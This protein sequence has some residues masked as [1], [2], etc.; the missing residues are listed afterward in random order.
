[1]KKFCFPI[2]ICF[3][4]MFGSHNIAYGYTGD[5][6]Y[7][8]NNSYSAVVFSSYNDYKDYYS[9]ANINFD[10][11]KNYDYLY[12]PQILEDKLNYITEIFITS[13]YCKL[14]FEIDEIKLTTCHFF[15]SDEKEYC[16]YYHRYFENSEIEKNNVGMEYYLF[17]NEY[18]PDQY[19]CKYNG[20]YFSISTE[21]IECDMTDYKF[22][23]VYFNQQ[24]YEYDNELYYLN[25]NGLY[26]TGWKFVGNH[27]Y[28]F[29]SIDGTAIKNRL[30]FIDGYVYQFNNSGVCRGKYTGYALNT[31]GEKIYYRY[32][33]AV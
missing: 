26:E 5:V 22:V 11:I 9:T 21:L 27:K 25:D 23:K 24:L 2:A 10:Y 4:A 30:A 13:E 17:G 7:N 28:Y 8:F 14:T 29:R 3:F 1:M 20:S 18:N 12:I 31:D 32:G 15:Q 33:I 19:Y 6:P 16:L